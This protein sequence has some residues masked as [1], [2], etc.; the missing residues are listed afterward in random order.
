ML[1]AQ[2]CTLFLDELPVL[3]A[4]SEKD[5]PRRVAERI[6]AAV[7]TVSEQRSEPDPKPTLL[8]LPSPLRL[9]QCH[10]DPPA[11]AKPCSPHSSAALSPTHPTTGLAAL[12]PRTL[13]LVPQT[14]EL[15]P[16]RPEEAQPCPNQ[17]LQ[18]PQE[19]QKDGVPECERVP[20][21]PSATPPVSPY[22]LLGPPA[23]FH[24]SSTV[25]S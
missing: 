15:G 6:E 5:L 12:A 19:L 22:L 21:L 20:T 13:G 4:A 24:R 11:S 8:P 7:H 1:Q 16:G 25:G 14:A 17:Q 10:S 9:P 23:P 3:P 18:V 2:R